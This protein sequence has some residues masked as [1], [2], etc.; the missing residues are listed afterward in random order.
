MTESPYPLLYTFRRCPYAMR[1]RMALSVS[2]RTC[3]VRELVLRDK[4]AH[5]LE[6]STKATV[7]VLQ[8][9][10]GTVIDE[11][12]D[13][14]LWA[15]GQNDPAQW[16]APERGDL[17]AMLALIAACE[18]QFKPHLDRYKYAN[19]FDATDPLEQ[20]TL[21]E[22][23]LARLDSQLLETPYLYGCRPAL[24]DTAIAPFVR[25]FANTDR[26]WF[27]QSPYPNLQRWLG[28]FLQSETFTTVMEKLPVWQPG[29]APTHRF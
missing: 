10:D 23:F 20:R 14:M 26:A 7:P 11:S 15:L 28:E 22:K 17:A 19:R 12:L 9:P 29:D 3:E 21:A 18:E 27:D 13:V 1:A 8:T 24:A 5:M 25:Q 6:I 4:P 2:G 16:L